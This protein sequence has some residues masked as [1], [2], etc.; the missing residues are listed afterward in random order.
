[1]TSFHLTIR[2]LYRYFFCFRSSRLV[3]FDSGYERREIEDKSNRICTRFSRNFLGSTD[4]RYATIIVFFLLSF[5]VDAFIEPS[6]L[7]IALKTRVFTCARSKSRDAEQAIALLFEDI[8]HPDECICAHTGCRRVML[9]H[10][11]RLYPPACLSADRPAADRFAVWI[12]RASGVFEL[13]TALQ[14]RFDWQAR[15][16]SIPCGIQLMS[17]C[18]VSL[19]EAF[20]PSILTMA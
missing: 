4:M 11:R 5:S 12:A 6:Y 7:D 14:G 18:A 16:L 3:S 19:K 13:Q 8:R 10:V 2:S 15:T 9:E 1:M 17:L 20:L